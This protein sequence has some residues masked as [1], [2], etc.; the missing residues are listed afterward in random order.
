MAREGYHSVT[1][2]HETFLILE[3]LS[4]DLGRSVPYVVDSMVR[5][6]KFVFGVPYRPEYVCVACSRVI[7]CLPDSD[8]IVDKCPV[9][10]GT[11]NMRYVKDE[12]K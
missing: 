12:K 11:L 6:R 4:R 9:C 7:Y 5:G 10:H 2:K 1:V 3:N 8:K